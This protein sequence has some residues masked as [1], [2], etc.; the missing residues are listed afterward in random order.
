MKL[1]TI[2]YRFVPV[3]AREIPSCLAAPVHKN[4]R[5]GLLVAPYKLLVVGNIQHLEEV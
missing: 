1:D 5:C 2:V 4:V 3:Q